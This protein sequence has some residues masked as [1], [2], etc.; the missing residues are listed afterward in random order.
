MKISCERC[1]KEIGF[2]SRAHELKNVNLNIEYSN[3][4]S[5][6]NS[7]LTNAISKIDVMTQS[8]RKVLLNDYNFSNLISVDLD[9]IIYLAI[10]AMLKMNPNFID[11]ND[12]L[13]QVFI[14]E[15]SENI[16]S[17]KELLSKLIKKILDYGFSANLEN[18]ELLS[19]SK[20]F[21]NTVLFIK[22]I[23]A[24]CS[25]SVPQTWTD[26]F[27]T[28][29]GIVLRQ[30]EGRQ[31]TKVNFPINEEIK[32]SLKKQDSL[33]SVHF[34][35]VKYP[36]SLFQDRNIILYSN[37]DNQ[38]R[39][40]TKLVD[41]FNEQLKEKED[42]KRRLI[43]NQ[44]GEQVR[45]DLRKLFSDMSISTLHIDSVLLIIMKNIK[46]RKEIPVLDIYNP[47][48]VIIDLLIRDYLTNFLTLGIRTRDDIVEYIQDRCLYIDDCNIKVPEI[49]SDHFWG[50]FTSRGYI[51]FLKQSKKYLF[52]FE[53]NY[54]ND[55]YYPLNNLLYQGIRYLQI[56]DRYHNLS[57]KNDQNGIIFYSKKIDNVDEMNRFFVKN[58]C[59][60]QMDFYME[61]RNETFSD[62]DRILELK[63]T[64]DKLFA[65]FGYIPFC[66]YDEWLTI[67][68]EMIKDSPFLEKLFSEQSSIVNQY[69]HHTIY[70]ERI[71]H[72]FDKGAMDLMKTLKIDDI[73]IAKGLMLEY[74]NQTLI[75]LL[76]EEW[77]RI[78][79]D[80]ITSNTSLEQSF[81]YYLN[82]KKIEP[83]KAYY[84]GLFVYY[85]IN[86]S[87]L[88]KKNNF[89][90]NYQR[91]MIVFLRCQQNLE[92]DAGIEIPS[93]M[94]EKKDS[95]AENNETTKELTEKR[96]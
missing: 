45:K 50:F 78:N 17:E 71:T 93:E 95:E 41:Y 19:Y 18:A 96:K 75:D 79:G 89:F 29:R 51:L 92:Y 69:K 83:Q 68:Q 42:Q 56:P 8:I 30:T 21:N 87:I 16:Y 20:Y 47:Y 74:L 25:Q 90:E 53:K 76:S 6:C 34:S 26:L 27:L 64:C 22:Q 31:V 7:L 15:N 52:V 36:E 58:N 49:Q 85:L 28:K 55:I 62:R 24:N 10:D 81:N 32:Y 3:L 38:L 44:V 80:Q 40:M 73:D 35:N 1:G 43:L 4:C 37:D 9:T 13:Y 88:S 67:Y 66:M 82:L 48:G 65:V 33:Q 2:F 77:I 11:R 72:A 14:G 5:K 61:Q 54:P 46:Q 59:D 57:K 23:Q 91:S 84:F 63:R 94:L 12:E 39:Q 60:Y 70:T 86:K